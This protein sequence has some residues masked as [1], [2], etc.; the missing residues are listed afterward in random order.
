MPALSEAARFE[1]DHRIAQT[2]VMKALVLLLALHESADSV[3]LQADMRDGSLTRL[4]VTY[5]AKGQMLGGFG[6]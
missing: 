3:Q 5:A 6:A 4:D 1:V 2:E